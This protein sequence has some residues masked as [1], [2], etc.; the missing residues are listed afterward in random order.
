MKNAIWSNHVRGI[1][2][3]AFAKKGKI[4]QASAAESDDEAFL[5]RKFLIAPSIA[6][7]TVPEYVR[8]CAPLLS[9]LIRSL[10]V[11]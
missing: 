10:A 2:K 8:S 5:H 6:T 9:G 11:D 3:S 1:T 7:A 4:P